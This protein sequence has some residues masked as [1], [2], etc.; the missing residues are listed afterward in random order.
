MATRLDG[1]STAS[2]PRVLKDKVFFQGTDNKLWETSIANPTNQADPLGAYK[3]SSSPC[4]GNDGN[5]YFQGTDNQLWQVSLSDPS[6]QEQPRR[7]QDGLDA[8]RPG[9]R[10]HLLPGHERSALADFDR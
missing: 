1:F 7:L 4:I 6:N 2:T 3:A 9:G 10:Q 5:I 8:L